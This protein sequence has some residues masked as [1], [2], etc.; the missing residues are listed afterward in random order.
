MNAYV[1]IQFLFMY[2]STGSCTVH[3]N[4]PICA[5]AMPVLMYIHI[6]VKGWTQWKFCPRL[7]KKLGSNHVCFFFIK[8][9]RNFQEL[10]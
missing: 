4:V 8:I 3:I 10:I 1:Y 6:S 7:H 9:G 5:P 2:L